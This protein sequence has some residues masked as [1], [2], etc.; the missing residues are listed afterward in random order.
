MDNTEHYG[1]FDKGSNP[2]GTS[3]HKNPL[4]MIREHK[5]KVNNKGELSEWLGRGLQNLLHW[6]ESNIHL[7]GCGL[8]VKTGVCGT[9]DKS[10]ILFNHTTYCG[11]EGF[12]TGLISRVSRVQFSAP[13]PKYFWF[14]LHIFCYLKNFIYICFKIMVFTIQRMS[15]IQNGVWNHNPLPRP[16]KTTIKQ[17]R[18]ERNGYSI[19]ILKAP[20]T[21]LARVADL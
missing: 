17:S 9:S 4:F 12:P 8:T 21:Q 14:F 13:Q 18:M 15:T 6:F 19:I 20:L 3:V 10:S 2:L 1:C 11:E 5:K 7:G 16:R